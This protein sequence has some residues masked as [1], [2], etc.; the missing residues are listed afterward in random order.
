LT[1]VGDTSAKQKQRM[2][3]KKKFR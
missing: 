2:F 3:R 1:T